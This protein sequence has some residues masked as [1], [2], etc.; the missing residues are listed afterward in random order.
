VRG[1]DGGRLAAA[2]GLVVLVLVGGVGCGSGDGTQTQGQGA[3]GSSHEQGDVKDF[4]G[5]TGV[6]SATERSITVR[7]DPVPVAKADG[8]CDAELTPKVL[9]PEGQA[10]QVGLSFDVEADRPMQNP[11]KLQ[12][13][14]GFPIKWDGCELASR[15]V[16]VQLEAPLAGRGVTDPFGSEFWIK[17]GRW[18]GC[19]QVAMT[20]VVDPAS[21]DGSTLHDSIANADVPRRF[22]MANERC[23]APY[24]V[25]DVDIGAGACPAT[26]EPTDNPCAD[27]N[28]TRMYWHIENDTWVQVGRTD[29]PGCGDILSQ[30]PDFPTKLCADLP[31]V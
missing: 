18:V 8:T 21:C 30:A 27:Q 2:V 11:D 16:T 19:D 29:G 13:E 26:G 5:I 25:V 17:D 9:D 6:E 7:T 1:A 4:V 28:V 10:G 23:E 15:T 20:C 22:G 24:A 12:D 31:A 3:S 14:N